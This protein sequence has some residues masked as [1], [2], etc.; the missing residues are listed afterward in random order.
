MDRYQDKPKPKSRPVSAIISTT[1]TNVTSHDHASLSSP[2]SATQL[3]QL[4]SQQTSQAQPTS[5]PTH[6]LRSSKTKAES[7]KHLQPP[8]QI[9]L[10]KALRKPPVQITKKDILRNDSR[11]AAAAAT[12]T[13]AATVSA[14]S[15][16]I[17]QPNHDRAELQFLISIYAP[18]L[19]PLRDTSLAE[20]LKS[21]LPNMVENQD[22]NLSLHLFLSTIMVKY[23]N[24]WYL[25][26]LNTKNLDFPKAVYDDI[27]VPTVRDAAKR[28]ECTSGCDLL[29]LMD[30]LASILNTHLEDFVGDENGKYSYKVLHDYYHLAETENSLFYDPSKDPKDI[31]ETCL[32]QRHAIFEKIGIGKE[33]QMLLYFRVMVKSILEKVIENSTKDPIFTSKITSDLLILILGDLVMSQIFKKVSSSEFILSS[34]NNAVLGLLSVMKVRE[35][36]KVSAASYRQSTISTIAAFLYTTYLQIGLFV[37]AVS[38]SSGYDAPFDVINS[39]VLVLAGTILSL[40]QTR[41]LLHNFVSSLKCMILSFPGLKN[42]LN[43]VAS[44]YLLGNLRRS[45]TTEAICKITNQLRLA[46][47][48]PESK[49]GQKHELTVTL[50]NVIDNTIELFMHIPMGKQLDR[51]VVRTKIKRVLTVF[52]HDEQL[53]PDNKLNQLLA[54]RLL[55][56]VIYAIY[57]DI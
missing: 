47:F 12:T 50:D 21:R 56:R 23:V 1:T 5:N 45:L 43:N 15:L 4:T 39:S 20:R 41:P 14:D 3:T 31:L 7:S 51:S 34:I 44:N 16:K 13:T 33:N 30:D 29:S 32:A 8:P 52:D 38:L 37:S 42:R 40:R 9:S 55:D 48:Y 2:S 19:R 17:N 35:E 26:K 28:I 36:T 11:A 57:N 24:S 25:T 27:L 6:L 54:I 22:I 18:G 10:E 53:D 49:D 46:L